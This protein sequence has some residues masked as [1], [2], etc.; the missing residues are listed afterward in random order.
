M[1]YFFIETMGCQ[2]N[3][4]DS[5]YM[6]RVLIQKGYRPT[7]LPEEAALILV[8]TCAVRAKPE[9]K[10]YS[11]LGRASRIKA[12]RP[13]VILGVAG[14]VAQ[15]E[16]DHLIQRFPLLDL[17]MGPREVDLF[18]D[19]LDR[20]L[21]RHARVLATDLTRPPSRF[22]ALPRTDD[23]SISAFIS[24]MQGCDNFCT[25]CVVPYVR[26]REFSRDPDDIEAEASHLISQ[27]VREI[28]LVGQNVN[29]YAWRGQ[30]RWNFPDLLRRIGTL[31]GLFRLRFTTSHPKDLSEEL[32]ICFKDVKNLC[33]HIHLP[34]Q[35]GSNRILKR[36]GRGYTRE[37]YRERVER[38]RSIRPDMAITSDVMVGFPGETEGDFEETLA[39][40]REIRFDGLFSFKYADRRGTAA[41]SM[42]EKVLEAPKNERLQI[43]QSLQAGITL[44]KNKALEGKEMEVL[45]EGESKKGSLL[46]G[47][48]GTNKIINFK[49]NIENIGKLVNVKVEQSFAHSLFAVMV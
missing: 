38:L 41:A 2:M 44:E 43:L 23:K 18:E 5:E 31:K 9:Q 20:A 28:T 17:V 7:K 19:I 42:P 4:Y 10:A 49:C 21:A 3:E 13:E 14:C 25:Y 22:L 11:F 29:S 15:M 30:G 47:R 48:T 8:N 24:I 26:G 16:K 32:M 37:I 33:P 1:K 46:T 6:A 12:R 36:M 35:S 34:F 45:V 39:L 40:I 27:G